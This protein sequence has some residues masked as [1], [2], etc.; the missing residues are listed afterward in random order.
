MPTLTWL[1]H[2]L[3]A[4][5]TGTRSLAQGPVLPRLVCPFVREVYIR[6]KDE[7]QAIAFRFRVTPRYTFHCE[8]ARYNKLVSV[9]ALHVSLTR[10]ITPQRLTSCETKAGPIRLS[11]GATTC[12]K[13]PRWCRCGQTMEASYSRYFV[14]MRWRGANCQTFCMK[15]FFSRRNCLRA[16]FWRGALVKACGYFDVNV[17]MRANTM[18]TYKHLF[19]QRCL[20]QAIFIPTNRVPD[21][22]REQVILDAM[23]AP[24]EG[25]EYIDLEHIQCASLTEMS[26]RRLDLQQF[27]PSALLLRRTTYPSDR[28]AGQKL[29]HQ[30][31]VSAQ[32][33]LE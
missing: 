24:N 2:A 21:H 32:D 7:R 25:R 29:R 1:L 31:S 6:K 10:G 12:T 16:S 27:L 15:A 22:R 23:T 18:G 4:A 5:L 14:I 3:S 9:T 20:C 8:H 13:S 17:A 30:W 26:R 33:T 19:W 28:H 11:A